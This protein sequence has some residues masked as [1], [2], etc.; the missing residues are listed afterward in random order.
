MGSGKQLEA[1]VQQIFTYLLNMKDEGVT[2]GRNVVLKGRS[3]QGHEI[4]VYY[5][6]ERAGIR[7]RVAI[8][9]KDWSSPVSKGEIHE[10]ES[11]IREIGNII[12]A[13]VSRNG[14]QSGCEKVAEFNGIILM[15]LSDLPSF[16]SLIAQ[17][18]K[19]VALPDET[20]V[21]EPFWTIMEL[22]DGRVTGSHLVHESRELG[23]LVPLTY[24]KA[25][26]ERLLR[27]GELDQSRWAVR[28]L[29]RHAFS[30]FLTILKLYET[31]GVSA[32]ICFL[33]PGAREDAQFILVKARRADLVR[34]YL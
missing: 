9:C 33:P 32:A 12:G 17:R 22:R 29:P 13:F 26:A 25:H 23:P 19:S 21:G 27:E 18:L 10:F 34:E 28:G 11:K 15:R 16:T 31:R 30:G 8:E 4:D 20:Y 14:F 3:G 6:F 1:D 2:V 5:E 7:H 24:S